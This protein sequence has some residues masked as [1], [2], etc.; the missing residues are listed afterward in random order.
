VQEVRQA[1]GLREVVVRLVP[2][3]ETQAG[4]GSEQSG[5]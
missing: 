1:M 2:E 3:A 4:N 5:A